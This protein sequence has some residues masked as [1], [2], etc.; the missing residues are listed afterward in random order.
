MSI[1]R[2][3]WITYIINS[4]K[5][6]LNI[7]LVSANQDNKLIISNKK[8]VLLFSIENETK[9]ESIRVSLEGCTKEKKHHFEESLQGYRVF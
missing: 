8:N 7:S 3:S 4:H 1:P 2:S 5:G 6:K 9:D